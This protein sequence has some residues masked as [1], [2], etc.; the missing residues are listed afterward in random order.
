MVRPL[1]HSSTQQSSWNAQAE[2]ML[3]V[4]GA[5]ADGD[6][7]LQESFLGDEDQP[8]SAPMQPSSSQRHQ[9]QIIRYQ[10]FHLESFIHWVLRSWAAF[11]SEW[12]F[13]CLVAPSSSWA[14]RAPHWGVV[15]DLTWD[16]AAAA[17]TLSSCLQGLLGG[18]GRTTLSLVQVSRP[19]ASASCHVQCTLKTCT[20]HL[21]SRRH[22]TVI[23][24]AGI[25]GCAGAAPGGAA[26]EPG[27]AV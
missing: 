6:D 20:C 25:A 24:A 27:S 14:S 5:A 15:S 18:G 19:F 12:G 1:P 2:L 16:A 26:G 4:G 8:S 7:Q 23:C 10:P 11:L 17:G 21:L 22:H 9:Q 3:P 13:I